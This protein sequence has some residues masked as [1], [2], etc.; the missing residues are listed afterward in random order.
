MW[1]VYL[2]ETYEDARTCKLQIQYI[3]L[4]S[5]FS[6]TDLHLIMKLLKFY[7]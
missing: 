3:N 7:K 6:L 1:L 5:K 4:G 2:F